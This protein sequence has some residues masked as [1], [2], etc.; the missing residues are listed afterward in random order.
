MRLISFIHTLVDEI[1]ESEAVAHPSDG[2]DVV[3]S[4]HGGVIDELLCK[5]S[6]FA[7]GREWAIKYMQCTGC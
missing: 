5:R 4:Q 6:G 2:W 7:H 1:D 3:D